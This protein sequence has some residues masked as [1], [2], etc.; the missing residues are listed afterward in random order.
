MSIGRR[1]CLPIINY[2][3]YAAIAP[4]TKGCCIHEGQTRGVMLFTTAAAKWA[5]STRSHVNK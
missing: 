3:A 5:S 2:S 1:Y 4:I